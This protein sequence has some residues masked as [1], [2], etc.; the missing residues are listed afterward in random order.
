MGLNTI[1]IIWGGLRARDL[2]VFD[3][4]GIL[5][6]QEHYGGIQIAPSP[7]LARRFDASLSGV[8][9]RDRNHPSIAIWCLLN[10]MWDGPQFRHG[11]QALPLVK[12]L[13]DTRLVWLNSGAFDLQFGQGSLSNPGTTEWQCLMGSEAPGMPGSANWADYGAMLDNQGDIKADIHPYQPVPHTAAEIER[14]RT[15]GKVAPPGRKIMI[16]EI[17]TGCAVN[18]PQFARHYEQMGAEQADDAVYYRDKLDQ[19]LADWNKWDLG[20]IWTRPEDYFT[21]SERNMI[22]LRRET[23]NALRQSAPGGL[24]LLRLPDSD[25]NGVG[26][27]NSFREF[28]PGVVELQNDLTSPVRWCLFAEPV[29]VYSGSTV[30]L[31]ALLSNLDVLPAG[32][33]PVVVEVVAP[34]G[35]RVFQEQLTVN[36]P[37]PAQAPEAPLVQSVFSKDVLITGPTGTHKF[38]VHFERGAAATGGEIA[39]QVFNAVEMPPVTSE[40]VLWGQDEDLAAW[41]TQHDIR[42]RP[43]SSPAAAQRELI[44]VGNVGGDLPA[45]RELAERMARGST[46]VFLSPSVFSRGG[47]P[48]GFL[49][50]VNK[51]A[52]AGTDS[53]GGYYRGD[54]FAPKHPVLEG[55]PSGGI[56][57]YTVYRNI[58]AQ[59]GGG[60]SGVSAPDD[61]IVAAIRPA[62]LCLRDPDGG[63]Q[64]RR[65]R[66]IFNTLRIRESLGTD[67]VAERLLRNLLN[68]AA[69]DLDQPVVELPADFNEQ[70]KAIGYE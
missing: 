42:T 50:L 32:D 9:R 45:F 70:L 25:F 40:A 3:E 7:D 48:W 54:T 11:V 5:V 28:K 56:L 20:R 23:G 18:L 61:L 60:L 69:H 19:F 36:I 6:Q 51:G 12:F 33:Y 26:L 43:Y 68:Y 64:L 29:N 27:L 22:K 46:I 63:L 2:D 24:L 1:R 52:W 21:D 39:F 53:V 66:F 16:T 34:D 47:Q 14:M 49:P 57:D 15:L 31:E 8:I 35:H 65:G 30:K 55:L 10:E 59:G 38:L 62:G 58:I 37:D 13:D 67:P 41:L 44:L 4:L 17:G